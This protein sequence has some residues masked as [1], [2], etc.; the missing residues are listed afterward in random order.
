MQKIHRC[1]SFLDDWS[2][3]WSVC[4]LASGEI[5]LVVIFWQAHSLPPRTFLQKSFHLRR[6]VSRECERIEE[7]ANTWARAMS[8]RPQKIQQG[9]GRKVLE[10][11]KPENREELC[12]LGNIT[13]KGVNCGGSQSFLQEPPQ[14]DLFKCKSWCGP[15]SVHSNVAFPIL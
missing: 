6:Q 15:R 7:V 13:R 1:C 5:H 10:R 2:V 4:P 14:V 3:L 11:Y 12:L 9:T 8:R